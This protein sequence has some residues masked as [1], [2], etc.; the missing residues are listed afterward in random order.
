MTLKPAIKIIF[1]IKENL[2]RGYILKGKSLPDSAEHAAT[3]DTEK[4]VY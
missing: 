1:K 3:V 4:I 2:R